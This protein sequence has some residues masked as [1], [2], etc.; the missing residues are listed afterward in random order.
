MFLH[1]LRLFFR[2]I[3]FVSLVSLTCEE[4]RKE[5]TICKINGA[6][7]GATGIELIQ[8]NL[9]EKVLADLFC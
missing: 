3:S 1:N 4:R 6:T 9:T 7:A 2:N 8:G 5:V